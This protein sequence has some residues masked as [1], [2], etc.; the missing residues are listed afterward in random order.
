MGVLAVGVLAEQYPFRVK[1]CVDDALAL[2]L[3][4]ALASALSL[5]KGLI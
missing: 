5:E 1:V 4:L 2:A 3:A